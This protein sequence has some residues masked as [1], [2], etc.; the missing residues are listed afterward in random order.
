MVFANL[1][2]SPP[3]PLCKQ[4]GVTFKGYLLQLL[5]GRPPSKKKVKNTSW[6]VMNSYFLYI[7]FY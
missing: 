6:I 4:R 7:S 1:V 5:C 3:S 2:D